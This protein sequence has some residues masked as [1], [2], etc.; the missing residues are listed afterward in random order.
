MCECVHHGVI[1]IQGSLYNTTLMFLYIV[2]RHRAMNVY[3]VCSHGAST[4]MECMQGI[5]FLQLWPACI[6]LYVFQHVGTYT[7]AIAGIA[8]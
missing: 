8:L 7:V 1:I 2:I 3:S 5:T 6:V 4:L